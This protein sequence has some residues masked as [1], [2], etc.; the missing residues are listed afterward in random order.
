MQV[1]MT[2]IH[3]SK[4]GLT[5]S[6]KLEASKIETLTGL[7]RE[8]IAMVGEGLKDKQIA[9]R[10]LIDEIALRHHL[11]SVFDKLQVNDRLDLVIYA[12]LHGLSMVP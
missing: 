4:L 5:E 10:L 6:E 8:I 9:E 1:I 3:R 2:D 11:K 12:Y 7:E